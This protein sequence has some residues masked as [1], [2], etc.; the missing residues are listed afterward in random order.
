[1]EATMPLDETGS[2]DRLSHLLESFWSATVGGVNDY[3]DKYQDV[4]HVHRPTTVRSIMRDHIVD[5][6]RGLVHGRVDVRVQDKNQT[7]YFLCCQQF[8]ILVKKADDEGLVELTKTQASWDFQTNDGQYIIDP[9]IIPEVTNLYLSYI[10]NPEDP[11]QPSVFLICPC[12]EG[13]LWRIEIEPPATDVSPIFRPDDGAPPG[14]DGEDE[15]DLVRL[16]DEAEKRP[17]E[18]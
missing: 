15:S 3:Y 14:K 11:M 1:M 2:R 6:M 13:F 8:R 18:E 10:P 17:E 12:D 7:T 5:R 16:P 9:T 4:A